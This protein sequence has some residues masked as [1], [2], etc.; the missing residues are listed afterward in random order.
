MWQVRSR[1]VGS[2]LIS[3]SISPIYQQPSEHQRLTEDKSKKQRLPA[4]EIAEDGFYGIRLAFWV[5]AYDLHP[6]FCNLDILHCVSFTLL[7]WVMMSWFLGMGKTPA[8]AR[9]R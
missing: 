8:S 7:L 5:T 3:A 2:L 6:L 4:R 1:R 9:E